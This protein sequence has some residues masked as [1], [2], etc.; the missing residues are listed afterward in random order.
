MDYFVRQNDRI[1]K[2]EL[3]SDAHYLHLRTL[4]IING[5][6][7]APDMM[8][9]EIEFSFNN[10][11][12]VKAITQDEYDHSMHEFHKPGGV[13]DQIEECREMARKTDPHDHGDIEK[14]NAFCSEV[15][16]RAR[17]ISDA[18]FVEEKRGARFDITHEATGKTKRSLVIQ[19]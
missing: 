14:T 9:S 19:Q 17:N 2:G 11:Y 1:A 12:G 3:G 16:T 8:E 18:V 13:R 15:A 7:D 5:C 4:G 6:I 10:T